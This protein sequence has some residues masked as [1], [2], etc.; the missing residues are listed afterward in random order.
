MKR[1]NEGEDEEGEKRNCLDSPPK[2]L[3]LPLPLPSISMVKSHSYT[4]ISS[5][6]QSTPIIFIFLLKLYFFPN[7]T[8]FLLHFT[9]KFYSL[10]TTFFFFCH[11]NIILGTA[12]FISYILQSNFSP[13]FNTFYA[14]WIFYIIYP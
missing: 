5:S 2:F 1:E 11:Q 13:F 3:V 6:P 12:S 9:I 7:L 8:K 14:C 10:I 4:H